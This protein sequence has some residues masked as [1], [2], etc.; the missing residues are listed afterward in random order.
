MNVDPFL[1]PL[2]KINSKGIKGLNVKPEIINFPENTRK[3]L[4]ATGVNSDFFF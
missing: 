3:K 4:L 2:I 1:T